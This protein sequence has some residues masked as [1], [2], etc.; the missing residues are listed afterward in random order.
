[1]NE[2]NIVDKK[3]YVVGIVLGICSIAGSLLIPAIGLILGIIGLV[4]NIKNKNEYV[5][6]IGIVLNV[7]GII[8][9]LFFII[10]IVWTSAIMTM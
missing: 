7:A 9:F 3:F 5:V 1:M 10:F 4:L 2:K 8:V 6:K